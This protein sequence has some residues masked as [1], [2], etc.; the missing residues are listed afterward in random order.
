MGDGV[1]PPGGDPGIGLDIAADGR[2]TGADRGTRG[3][4]P[5]LAVGPGHV[6]RVHIVL[7]EPDMGHGRYRLSLVLLG[8]ADPGH[9]IAAFLHH[10]AADFLEQEAFVFR[11]QQGAIAAAECA[12]GAVQVFELLAGGTLH[13]HDRPP[14]GG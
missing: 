8:A 12:Q 2:Y 10:H 9:A 5:A 13:G 7:I 4:V 6:Q 3:T 1:F 14:P 11:T